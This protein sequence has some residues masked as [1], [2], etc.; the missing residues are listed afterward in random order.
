MTVKDERDKPTMRFVG[1]LSEDPFRQE[2]WN[3]LWKSKKCPECGYNQNGTYMIADLLKAPVDCECTK[4]LH[5][6]SVA[7]PLGPSPARMEITELL[8]LERTFKEKAAELRNIICKLHG[9]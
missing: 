5:K 4:C 6:W 9:E 3:A 1:Y 2:F 8:L 7:I